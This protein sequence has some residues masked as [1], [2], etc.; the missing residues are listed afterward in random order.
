MMARD[1]MSSSVVAVRATTPVRDIARL[2]LEKHISAVPV[3]DGAGAPIGII[4][5]G[6]LIVADASEGRRDRWL[7]MLAEG[8]PLSAEFLS[9]LNERTAGDVMSKPVVTVYEDTDLGEIARILQGSQIKRAP[10]VRNGRMVGIVSRAD[11]LRAIAAQL[12]PH[13]VPLAKSWLLPLAAPSPDLGHRRDAAASDGPPDS[14]DDATPSVIDFRQLVTDHEDRE[15]RR[16]EELRKD[17]AEERRRS[18]IELTQK[19]ISDET[20]RNL[21]HQARL[22]AQT[23]QK[24]FMLLRFPSELCSDGGRAVNAPEPEWPITLRGEAAEAYQRW[25]R[26][27]APRGFHLAARVVN[28]PHGMP[29][30][31]GLFLV[32]GE[33]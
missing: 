22:A 10:V 1:V 23:G 24:E 21:I 3:V 28:F 30:D 26:D 12:A 31:I 7:A 6:D 2:L 20:W 32:W 17:A 13:G 19:H 4:S 9:S 8:E 18:A 14:A 11:V 25:E 33:A 16:G 27:L 5:E 29:G 15:R